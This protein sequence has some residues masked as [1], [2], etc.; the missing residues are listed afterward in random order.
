M[1]FDFR[2]LI[3]VEHEIQKALKAKR[4]ICFFPYIG[5]KPYAGFDKVLLHFVE[6]FHIGKSIGGGGVMYTSKLGL[7]GENSHGSRL[8]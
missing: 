8:T 6:H 3:A 1:G 2:P 5:E 4:R 7:F